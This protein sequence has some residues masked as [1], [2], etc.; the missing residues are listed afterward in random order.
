MVETT[1]FW[2]PGCEDVHVIPHEVWQVSNGISGLTIKPS[3]LMYEHQKFINEDLK[4]DALLDPSNITTAPRCHSFVTD[5]EI[6]FLSD[7][8]HALANQTVDVPP[9]PDWLKD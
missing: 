2:C 6:Q 4:W 9:L 1:K 3:I 7:S 8:T 5:G